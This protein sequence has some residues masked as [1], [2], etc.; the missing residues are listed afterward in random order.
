MKNNLKAVE[1]PEPPNPSSSIKCMI[2]A[3]AVALRVWSQLCLTCGAYA[4]SI[5]IEAERVVHRHPL[6]RVLPRAIVLQNLMM[7]ARGKTCST[8]GLAFAGS[9]YERLECVG[10]EK[11]WCCVRSCVNGKR[12][13]IEHATC[14]GKPSSWELKLKG[15]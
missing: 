12:L 3:K 13:P 2:C 10:C 8:C 15:Y 11:F 14:G 9:S 1:A 4:C 6:H 5:C 7:S